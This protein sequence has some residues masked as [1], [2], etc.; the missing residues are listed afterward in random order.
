MDEDWPKGHDVGSCDCQRCQ[1]VIN[2]WGEEAMGFQTWFD[3]LPEEQLR[4]YFGLT[5]EVLDGSPG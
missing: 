5:R 3:R 1:G 4:R 2:E